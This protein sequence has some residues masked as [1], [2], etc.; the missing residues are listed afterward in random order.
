MRK[1]C[2]KRS[3]VLDVGG[4]MGLDW[5]KTLLLYDPDDPGR[6]G[7]DIAGVRAMGIDAIE[8]PYKS[9]GR[10]GSLTKLVRERRKDALIFTRNDEMEGAPRIGD[11][12]AATK[13]GYTTVSAI[14]PGDVDNQTRECLSDLLGEKKR[15]V[16]PPI[17][18]ETIGEPASDAA[19]SFSLIFDFEQLGCARYGIPR[20]LPLIESR[21]IKAVFFTT[22]FM[23]EL[24]PEVM[25]RIVAG[26]HE[27]GIHGTM[28]EFL[29][30]RP[31]DE[32]IE[33]IHGNIRAIGRFAVPTG[34]NYIFRMDPNSLRA[35]VRVGLK[36]FVLF[37]KHTYY[38]SRF[39]PASCRP[40]VVRT[41]DGDITMVPVAAETYS[42]D[43]NLIK[44]MID[45]AL[46]RAVSEHSRHIGVLMHPFKDGCLRRLPLT[47]R[48][49]DYLTKD[50][51]LAPELLGRLPEPARQDRDAVRVFFR[52]DGYE[53]RASAG[54]VREAEAAPWWSKVVYHSLRTEALVRGL[55]Q[56]PAGAVLYAGTPQ[57]SGGV[58]VFPDT[59]SRD[60]VELTCNPLARHLK[61]ADA[62]AEA[63]RKSGETCIVPPAR[64]V[65]FCRFVV[66]HLPRTRTEVGLL[67]RKFWTRLLG[68]HR[69]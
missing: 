22:G 68:R 4:K 25:G 6:F 21:G 32:Q 9:I 45:S 10:D 42:G 28:H 43:F 12:L 57:E 35:M 11:L 63:L 24:Y 5:R 26:G 19:C 14:D 62:V 50:L 1:S 2:A 38:R 69:E 44:G 41:R 58:R 60:A 20:L 40:A 64:W 61:W 16:L 17:P 56:S 66:F 47:I 34:A 49:L 37:R 65:D 18:E 54:D 8:V 30:D 39:I 33:R 23:A 67:L 46:K 29:Q 51:G 15:V 7:L 53:P 36:Y 3:H 48:I 52:W 59:A 27:I 31:L 13:M 55:E